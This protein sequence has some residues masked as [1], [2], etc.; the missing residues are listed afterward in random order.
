VDA[1]GG[2]TSSLWDR[3]IGTMPRTPCQGMLE[4]MA[5]EQADVQEK[6]PGIEA[7]S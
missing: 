6:E 3:L 4:A 5:H 1:G 7:A 2:A